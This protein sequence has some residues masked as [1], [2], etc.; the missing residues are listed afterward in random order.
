MA[1]AAVIYEADPDKRQQLV[2]HLQAQA[3]QYGMLNGAL[4]L[5][6]KE[7]VTREQ[8]KAFAMASKGYPPSHMVI[9]A[10]AEEVRADGRLFRHGTTVAKLFEGVD[11]H[12]ISYYELQLAR[13]EKPAA[14]QHQE[15]VT[16]AAK[17]ILGEQLR[18]TRELKPHHADM[19]GQ[20]AAG[21]MDEA[22][23]RRADVRKAT[24]RLAEKLANTEQHH[25]R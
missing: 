4:V 12:P 9:V 18:E 10:P 25:R 17:Q 20:I 5:E 19:I 24:D 2:E 7:P 13:E 16:V 1:E 3:S 11:L 22:I 15:L 23:R 21:E 14:T 8:Q 6:V